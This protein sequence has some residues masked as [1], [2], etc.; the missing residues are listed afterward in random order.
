MEVATLSFKYYGE[1]NK[2]YNN[3]SRFY[4]DYTK[5]DKSN[6]DIYDSVTKN[7]QDIQR[8]LKKLGLENALEEEE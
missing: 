8:I 3:W 5:Q 6:N 4:W 1:E 7:S 2:E